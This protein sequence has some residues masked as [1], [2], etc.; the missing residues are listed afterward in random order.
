MKYTFSSLMGVIGAAI[1]SLFGGWDAAMTTLLIFMGI[2]YLLG[3][4]CAAMARSDK[5]ANGKLSSKA[6]WKGL[7]KKGVTLIIVLV[8]YRLDLLIG[9]DYIKDCVVIAYIA[10]ETLSIIENCAA[11][12][13]PVPNVL[14]KAIDVINLKSEGEDVQSKNDKTES[15]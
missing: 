8:A 12:G 2:D 5:S 1:A 15:Q 9:S 3:I 6:G 4:I 11:I 10:M 14:L 13:L 7:L